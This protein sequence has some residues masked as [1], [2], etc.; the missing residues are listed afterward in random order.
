MK[1]MCE[2]VLGKFL[3]FYT[4]YL[5]HCCSINGTY[6]CSGYRWSKI[7][8]NCIRKCNSYNNAIDIVLNCKFKKSSYWPNIHLSI[9]KAC[10][11][12]YTGINCAT[13]C[14]YPL[15]GQDCQSVCNCTKEHC[16]HVDG[17]RNSSGKTIENVCSGYVVRCHVKNLI[18]QSYVKA[19][20]Q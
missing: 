1:T 10:T 11:S 12:G 7:Q 9:F 2:R 8:N 6:C 19:C 4:I 14:I 13:K 18:N 5:Y 17:C 15:F 20:L 3:M 16:D